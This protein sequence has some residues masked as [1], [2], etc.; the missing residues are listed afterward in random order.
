[1]SKM[2][3][4]RCYLVLTQN[5]FYANSQ[6]VSKHQLLD[7]K[8]RHS[9]FESN[10]ACAAPS[11]P[12]VELNSPFSLQSVM[13]WGGYSW[14]LTKNYHLCFDI[15]GQGALA[16]LNNPAHQLLQMFQ[17]PRSVSSAL[18]LTPDLPT[19]HEALLYLARTGLLQPV[20][21]NIKSTDGEL[22]ALTAWLHVTNDCN[23]RCAYCYVDKTPDKMALEQG[24]RAVNA[25]FRSAIKQNFRHIKLKYA[26]GEATMN[27]PTVL[28]LH[29]YAQQLAAQRDLELDGVVLSNGVAISDRMIVAMQEMGLRLM[30]SLDGVGAYH[31]G[32]RPFVNGHGSF[33]LLERTLDRLARH[34]LTPS[35]S[36]TISQ[37]NLNGLPELVSYV[38]ERN[39]PFVFNFF[40][41]NANC[42]SAGADLRYEEDQLIEA[43]LSAFK[44]IEENPPPY[45][46]LGNLLDLAHLDNAHDHTCGVGRSY[47]VINHQGSVAK[48]HMALDETVGSITDDD[49]L[50]LIQLDQIGIQNLPVSEKEGCRTCEW[51]NWC[52]G[53]CPALT[54]RVTGR[55]DLKS[56]NCRI[57]KTLFPEVLK[58]EGLRLLKYSKLAVV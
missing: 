21:A 43:M 23:L 7:R 34:Q 37:H 40:R 56:P 57:Y 13:Q 5:D 44:V 49:P 11:T 39:L 35:I 16:I 9:L 26:G 20:T 36:I 29:R 17:T 38:L 55:Y 19:K 30:I 28:A 6:V 2:N 14:P 58:L 53:G 47:M 33:Y 25:V 31:D 12:S 10:C 15:A 41:D 50:Q 24:Y 8:E 1:M 42:G 4:E 45:S 18:A 32:Q 51:R 27:F 52:A 48:C 46:L 54:Y 3:S 22:T